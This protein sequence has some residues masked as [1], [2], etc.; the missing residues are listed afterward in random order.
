MLKNLI[1][2]YFGKFSS[3][4]MQVV[5]SLILMKL[6]E[7]SDFG[8]IGMTLA[9]N[10]F[11]LTFTNFGF[12]SYIIQQPKEDIELQSS[13]FWFNLLLGI[14]ITALII[15]TSQTIANFYHLQQLKNIIIICG[16]FIPI[17]L[18]ISIPN[19]LLSKRLQFKQINLRNIIVAFV[20]A[21]VG[22][23]AALLGFGVWALVVQQGLNL[24]FN[25]LASYKSAN[26]LPKFI[27]DRLKFKRA[28]NFGKYI[29]L[30]NLVESVYSR[31][32]VFTIGKI[33]SLEIVGYYT[34]AQSLSGNVIHMSSNSLLNV[35][36]PVLTKKKDDKPELI[37]NY[38]V[39]LH[40]ICFVFCL[41]S[42][43]CFLFAQIAFI[44]F[45]KPTWSYAAVLFKII[46]LS[47][48]V[49]PLSDLMLSILQ[50]RGNSRNYFV[51][52]VWKKVVLYPTYIILF[53][54]SIEVYLYTT[55]FGF[56]LALLINLY[57]LNKEIEVG[58]IK[59]IKIF[60][61]YFIPTIILSFILDYFIPTSSSWIF[62]LTKFMI[63]L[64][65]LSL[66]LKI[67]P[68]PTIQLILQKI[69]K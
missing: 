66:S 12:S 5:T 63:V 59:T 60:L 31:L 49:I 2:D 57:F 45:F 54:Y 69:K 61:S 28:F 6:L 13:I 65:A 44:T 25:L 18:L 8:L 52:D 19:A 62:S 58:Y 37:K 3:A 15:F 53:Y 36:F 50:A 17:G 38:F 9:V 10:S 42:S 4:L 16:L 43:F 34:R 48:V 29:F 7:P 22:I 30:A 47:S 40:H 11:A 33:F 21:I 35:L 24:L 68:S 26:W 55:F 20:C 23:S 46:I 39:Y 27:F 14:S 41:L 56:L 1:W 67:F 64:M 32:D 51:A